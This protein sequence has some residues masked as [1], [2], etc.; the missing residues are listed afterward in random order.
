MKNPSRMTMSLALGAALALAIGAATPSFAIAGSAKRPPPGSYLST[1][2][3][4]RVDGDYLY[5]KCTKK[6]GSTNDAKLKFRSCA[7]LVENRD[8][9]LWCMPSL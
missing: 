5:A 3:D 9:K 1:C 6:D 4:V 8:G 2:T 7:G